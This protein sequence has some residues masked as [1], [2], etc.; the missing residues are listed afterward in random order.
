MLRGRQPCGA[1]HARR[2]YGTRG[3]EGSGK[4]EKVDCEG[5]E[6]ESEG[7]MKS[8]AR[9]ECCLG[10]EPILLDCSVI[11]AKSISNSCQIVCPIKP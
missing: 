4:P 6:G 3:G 11:P 7:V 2:R 10:S 9:Q 5:G 1:D 8:A